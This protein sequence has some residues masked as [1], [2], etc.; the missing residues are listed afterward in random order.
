[1]RCARS[2]VRSRN[3]AVIAL[4]MANAV[5][6]ATLCVAAAPAWGDPPPRPH[7]SFTTT[8]PPV[9]NRSP[10]VIIP[11]APAIGPSPAVTTSESPK[12]RQIIAPAVRLSRD[13]GAP[14]T[15]FSAT[16]TGSAPCRSEPITLEWDSNPPVNVDKSTAT[17]N[18]TVPVDA[19]TGPHKVSATCNGKVFAS[20]PFTVVEKPALTIDPDK[21]PPGSQ[22]QAT[23]TGFAC[24]DDTDT[25]DIA[26]DSDVRGHG[27]SGRFSEQVSIPA[28]AP[29]GDHTVVASCHNHPD[30]TDH[31]TFTVT[32]TVTTTVPGPNPTPV[33][34]VTSSAE[35][36]PVPATPVPATPVP[37]TPVPPTTTVS[38]NP[39][40]DT[41]DLAS[42]W[43]VLVLI[44]VAVALF[45]SVRHRLNRPRPP[46]PPPVHAVSRLAGPPLVTVHET[47]APG[48]S[49]HALRLETH[50]GAHTLTVEEVN[51]GHIPAE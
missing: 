29:V 30:I 1:M 36:T 10:V 5:A 13:H 14:G 39:V 45:G 6:L 7:P 8:P 21:G 32:S 34:P 17:A 3:A 35:L 49:T 9:P 20:S 12:L 27:P 44:A 51:D 37:A 11:S 33:A 24:G 2:R 46:K 15:T 25:V 47:P 42:Y 50:S 23:G 22:L 28:T 41:S 4:V 19:A 48:E 31:Q 40:N 38:T 26:L 43:W 18:F 16:V